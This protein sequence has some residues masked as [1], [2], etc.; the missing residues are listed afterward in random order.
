[1]F[2]NEIDWVMRID[3]RLPVPGWP[4]GETEGM[5]LKMTQY[6]AEH[7]VGR[8]EVRECKCSRIKSV[9]RSV[10][11]ERGSVASNSQAEI[12]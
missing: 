10:T 5:R 1:M 6:K 9:F 4:Q 8:M 2:D 11:R 7:I 3:E 12:Q